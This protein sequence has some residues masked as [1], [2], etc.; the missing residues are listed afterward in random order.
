MIE[1]ISH[2]RMTI[3]IVSIVAPKFTASESLLLNDPRYI[4]FLVETMKQHLNE[5][6]TTR[7]NASHFALKFTLSALWN[8]TGEYGRDKKKKRGGGYGR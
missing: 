6:A 1:V 8:L 7:D 2:Y 4:G 3:A 5:L